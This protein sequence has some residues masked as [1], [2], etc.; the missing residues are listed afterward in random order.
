MQKAVKEA[1]AHTSW[2]HPSAAYDDAVV[3][4]VEGALNGRA[5]Q[6]FLRLFVP[7]VSRVARAGA[8]NSLSQL[9]LKIASPGVPD[10][11]QGTELWDLSLV[12]PDNRRP[13]D[14]DTRERWLA[15]AIAWIDEADPDRRAATLAALLDGWTDGR[16]KLF[17]TAAGLRLRRRRRGLFVQGS[18]VPLDT[19]GAHGGNL[20]AFARRHGPAVAIAVVPRLGSRLFGAQAP[21]PP[22]ADAWQDTAIDIPAPLDTVTFTHAWTGE[23]IVCERDG[24]R[25]WL[26]ASDLFRHVPAALLVAGPEEAHSS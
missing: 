14:Y 8:V 12:D 6:A 1:K 7:F 4:F 19:T 2:I 16:I 21:R 17:L 24:N 20:V 25:A 13:V 23:T 22:A 26:R 18:Y 15:E 10:F 5:S 11:Y 9:V 3:H